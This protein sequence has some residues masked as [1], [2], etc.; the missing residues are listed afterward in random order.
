MA[1]LFEKTRLNNMEL[2]N[3]SVRSATWEGL[4]DPGG[5]PTDGLTRVYVDLARGGVGMIVTGHAY[6]SEEGQAGRLQLGLCRDDC[7]PSY[8]RMTGAVHAA[9]GTIVAQ[10]AHAGCRAP[11]GLT[12]KPP[13]GPSDEGDTGCR[14]DSRGHPQS[15][16]GLRSG[17]GKGSKGRL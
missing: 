12:G 1:A 2:S 14:D 10:L 9:G 8:E 7:I 6:V 5:F 13:I 15:E 17:R 4:A 16:G 11:S 3:R